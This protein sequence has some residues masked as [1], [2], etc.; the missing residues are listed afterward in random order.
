[1]T[2]CKVHYTN[3][4]HTPELNMGEYFLSEQR[5]AEPAESIQWQVHGMELPQHLDCW[6]SNFQSMLF[7]R[8]SMLYILLYMLATPQAASLSAAHVV[9]FCYA[10]YQKGYRKITSTYFVIPPMSFTHFNIISNKVGE[11]EKAISEFER[12]PAYYRLNGAKIVRRK[13]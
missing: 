10:K 12:D 6:Y 5:T 7:R 13:G 8:I 2:K 3:M 4:K 9:L 11:S 1:M